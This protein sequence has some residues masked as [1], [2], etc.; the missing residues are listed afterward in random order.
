MTPRTQA[1]IALAA[2]WAAW[3]Y[4][5]VFRTPHVQKRA[6]LTV[7]GPTRMGLL[8]EAAA[9]GLTFLPSAGFLRTGAASFLGS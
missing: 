9:V 6:S 5:F 2:Y 3:A 8:L 4:P 1:G 7:T